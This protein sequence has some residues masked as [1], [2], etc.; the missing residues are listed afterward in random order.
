MKKVQLERILQ[1]LASVPQPKPEREPYA[2]PA[3]I[4]AEV[5]YGAYGRGDIEGCTVLDLGCGNGGLGI[6]AKLLRAARVVGVDSDPAAIRVAEQNAATV[7]VEAEWRID[8]VADVREAFDTVLMNPPFGAQIRHADRP[9]L[10]AALRCG[11]VVYTFL[12][13]P[14]EAFVRRYLEAAGATITDRFPY[15]FPIPH[16]FEFHRDE[17]RRIDVVLFR[18]EVAKG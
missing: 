3:T 18:V 8:E 4:A 1:S 15:S 6:A 9:F 14:A 17:A 2:T 16:T 5:V 7:R 13:G 10:D 12:N 11:R